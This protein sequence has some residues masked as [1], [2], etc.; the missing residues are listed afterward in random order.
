MD[1]LA[2]AYGHLRVAVNALLADPEGLS[3]ATAALDLQSVLDDLGVVPTYVRPCAGGA[4]G[5]LR[6]ATALVDACDR[7]PLGLRVRLQVLLARVES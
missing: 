1:V 2:D 4:A 7:A 3:L 5:S 6:A